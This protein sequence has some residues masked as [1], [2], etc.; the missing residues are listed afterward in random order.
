MSNTL[1]KVFKQIGEAE[2]SQ[3]AMQSLGDA[4]GK[5]VL[6]LRMRRLI[7]SGGGSGWEEIAPQDNGGDEAH[8]ARSQELGG[9]GE[10]E[11]APAEDA[12]A[13]REPAIDLDAVRKEAFAEGYSEGERAGSQKALRR[14]QASIE[15]FG[16]T[17]QQLSLLKPKLRTEAEREMVDL[18]LAVARRVV[19]RELSVD[20]ATVLGIVRACL[21]GFERGR[22]HRVTV[23]PADLDAVNEYFEEH[24]V[25]TL[26]VR[27]DEA[28]SPGGAVFETPQ[29]TID[30]RIETQLE[31]IE[32]GLTD[33]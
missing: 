25:E 12:S 26:E 9:D 11:A 19:R 5:G 13:G 10:V 28:I 24:P 17:V 1:S 23:S 18:S 33:R 22:P 3:L 21:E 7:P 14:L 2:V 8:Q 6:P 20:P 27:A 30:A 4:Y 29:G 31:E 16:Q 15:G 32:R